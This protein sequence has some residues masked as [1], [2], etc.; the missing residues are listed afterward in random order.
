MSYNTIKDGAVIAIRIYKDCSG[1]FPLADLRLAFGGIKTIRWD[2]PS[3][4]EV[5]KDGING[6]TLFYDER[7]TKCFDDILNRV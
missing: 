6:Y 2:C 7:I 5:Y 1:I 4:R 3:E